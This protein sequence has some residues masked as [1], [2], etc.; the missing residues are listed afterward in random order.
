MRVLNDLVIYLLPLFLAMSYF[1]VSLSNSRGG[2]A[3]KAGTPMK[4]SVIFAFSS[5]L[6]LL[7]GFFSASLLDK[8]SGNG[9]MW[10]SLS[11]LVLIAVRVIF[12]V[13][14]KK[15]DVRV[16]DIEQVSVIFAMAL[17]L[18]INILFAGVA[19]RFMGIPIFRS[20]L[21]LA[22]MVWLLSFSGL[23]YGNQFKGGFG[24]IVE[25]LAGVGII[26]LAVAVYYAV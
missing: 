2:K 10:I 16:F 22:L 1:S 14:K 21:I 20:G 3:L 5:F 17:A 25:M 12:S 15:A 6:L 19:I 23:L 11:L 4:A 18:G 24:R 8:Y 26:V 7:A 9:G 13:L